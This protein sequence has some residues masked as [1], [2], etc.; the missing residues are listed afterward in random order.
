MAPEVIKGD[1]YG[2]R[3]DIWSVGCT[4]VEMLTAV[5]PWPGM[6]NTWTA[7][8]HIAKASSGPPIP[9]GITEVIEDFLSRC[10]QLDPRKRPTST[11][12]LQ[13]PFVAETPP[14]T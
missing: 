11:E 5:H 6:D 3:A 1:G 2:R 12:L 10:F 8:F 13:H 4:V 9:E 14:E 7:I